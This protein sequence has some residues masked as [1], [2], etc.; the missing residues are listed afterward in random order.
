MQRI[1]LT[2][3]LSLCITVL[4]AQ[5]QL[6]PNAELKG[7]IANY[8]N[9]EVRVFNQINNKECGTFNIKSGKFTFSTYIAEPTPFR[10][11]NAQI[12]P[13]SF[14]VFLE[15]GKMSLA[16]DPQNPKNYMVSG[17]NSQQDY[18]NFSKMTE[19]FMIAFEKIQ[20]EKALDTK[21]SVELEQRVVDM[22]EGY[23]TICAEFIKSHPNR[24]VA[25]MIVYEH[26]RSMPYEM[27]LKNR[28][29]VFK[30]LSLEIQNSA[31]GRQIQDLL[32]AEKKTTIGQEFNFAD[33]ANFEK[34][35]QHSKSYL[36]KYVLIDFW[37]SWCLPCRRENPTL[38]EAFN[39]YKDD[40][41]DIISISLDTD[42]A[43]WHEAIEL[44]NLMGW[45]NLSELKGWNSM[46][47]NRY[48][49]NSIPSNFLIDP[50]GK[51]LAKNLFG[52][53]LKDT[54]DQLL[55]D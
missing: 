32:N 38:K 48:N 3:I 55:N 14:I 18:Q 46:I 15:K 2:L 29:G 33:F 19:R 51:I 25:S 41:F 47:T 8:I 44:D 34:F 43:Q 16:P 26:I 53:E 1:S 22:T 39:T 6:S 7:K 36:G 4:N 54:L 23:K 5:N 35:E 37:A 50:D 21:S 12:F 24:Y 13:K 45:S 30:S 31:Y 20:V 42:K 17:S 27:S 40:K 11:V 10:L 49:I 28:E 9:G 52:Q